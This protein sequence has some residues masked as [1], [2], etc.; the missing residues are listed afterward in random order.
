MRTIG[1]FTNSD[2][3]ERKTLPLNSRI[4]LRQLR[5]LKAVAEH[6]TIAAAA[7]TLGLTGP[8]I[9]SQLK[10]LEEILETPVL[11]TAAGGRRAPTAAGEA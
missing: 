10:N 11:E 3:D 6:G 2:V 5:A 4:T 7:D 9:H 8:A 1:K